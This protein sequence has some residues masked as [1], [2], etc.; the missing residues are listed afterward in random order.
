MGLFHGIS[1]VKADVDELTKLIITLNKNNKDLKSV[2]QVNDICDWSGAWAIYYFLLSYTEQEGKYVN[3]SGYF[4]V[5][6]ACIEELKRRCIQV[7]QA[8][9]G[10]DY[11]ECCFED[12][13][14]KALA[15]AE[16]LLPGD[17]RGY[18]ESYFYHLEHT[19]GWCKCILAVD[20]DDVL[21]YWSSW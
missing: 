7:L 5:T 16:E 9:Y 17:H 11:E 8:N 4:I 19:I 1:S 10:D 12:V 14:P 2:M 13:K 15:C 6:R 3:K 21:V 18:G 20:A